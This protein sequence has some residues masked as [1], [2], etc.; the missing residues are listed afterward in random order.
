M[1]SQRCITASQLTLMTTLSDPKIQGPGSNIIEAK[2]IAPGKEE[3]NRE[4]TRPT[5][6]Q[7]GYR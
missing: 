5:P 2:H 6:S 1:R 7:N 4:L 3:V